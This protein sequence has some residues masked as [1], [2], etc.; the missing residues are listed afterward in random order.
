MLDDLC[1]LDRDGDLAREEREE[2]RPFGR[3]GRAGQI[4]LEVD[5]PD[6]LALI[7]DWLTEN[8]TRLPLLD[9]RIRHEALIVLCVVDDD[10]LLRSSREMNDA[11]RHETGTVR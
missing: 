11:E 4:V 3:E 2:A 1:V 9:V 5:D 6:K 10:D 7:Q 8:G